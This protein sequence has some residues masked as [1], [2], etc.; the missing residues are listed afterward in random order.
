MP[1]GISEQPK[2][3]DET[4]Q[5]AVNRARSAFRDCDYSFGIESGLMKVPHTLTGSMDF[6]V[7]AVYDGARHYL[8]LSSAFEFPPVI[9]KMI[10]E[11]DVTATDAARLCGLTDSPNIGYEEGIVGILTKGIVTRKDYTMQAIHMALIQVTNSE[12]YQK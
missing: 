7:C 1:S 9:T 10:H 3:L 8:G 6:C 2:S 12:L 4:V 11:R 5:G